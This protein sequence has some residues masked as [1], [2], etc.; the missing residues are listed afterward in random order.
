M[1]LSDYEYFVD[2]VRARSGIQL[3]PEDSD[4]AQRRLGAVAGTSGLRTVDSLLSTIRQS[5]DEPVVWAAIEAMA[6]HET[7]FF[8]DGALFDHFRERVLPEFYAARQGRK[9]D[10]WCAACST[11]QEPYSLAMLVD[12]ERPRYPGLEVDILGS[13]LSA[14]CL[15]KAQAGVYSQ[16]EAQ[17]GLTIRQLIKHCEADGGSWRVTSAVRQAVRWTPQNLVESFTGLGRFDVVFCRNALVYFDRQ[18]QVRVLEQM[19]TML[20]PDGYLYLGAEETLP[21]PS[22]ALSAVSDLHGLYRKAAQ[23]AVNVA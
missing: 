6:S 8:R 21:G 19:A 9:L 10:V 13:D 7:Y 20:A 11:G 2:L 14:R 1:S 15:E 3:R 5:P 22:N 12:E 4:M 23:R 17:R 16:Y 18:T